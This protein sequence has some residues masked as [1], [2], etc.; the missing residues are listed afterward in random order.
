MLLR[1]RTQ[2][3]IA[4]KCSFSLFVKIKVARIK[5]KVVQLLELAMDWSC[6]LRQVNATC[7][8]GL[9]ELLG[10]RRIWP[11]VE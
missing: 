3:T 2:L 8:G 9:N 6:A 1:M 4:L 5:R 11:N 7:E 10:G